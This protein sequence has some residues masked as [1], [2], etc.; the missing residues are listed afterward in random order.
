MAPRF[1][2]THSTSPSEVTRTPLACSPSRSGE[3]VN[4]ASHPTLLTE[5]W[6][7]VLPDF[8]SMNTRPASSASSSVDPGGVLGAPG[9]GVAGVVGAGVLGVGECTGGRV[10]EGNVGS[11]GPAP[12]PGT[13]RPSMVVVHPA[14]SATP[15]SASALPVFTCSQTSATR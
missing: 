1:P 12:G 10:V 9:P 14:T 11:G 5:I 6:Q 8:V 2:S 3:S 15:S 13:G 7:R 4:C